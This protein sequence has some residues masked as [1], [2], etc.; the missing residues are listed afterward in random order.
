VIEARVTQQKLNQLDHAV[1]IGNYIMQQLRDAGIP[2]IGSLF[3]LSVE[4]GTLSVR[5]GDL[6]TDD[7]IYTWVDD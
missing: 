6:A 7:L 3:P 2:V 5:T 4:R 1:H